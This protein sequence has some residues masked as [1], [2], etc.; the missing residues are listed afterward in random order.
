MEYGQNCRR[1]SHARPLPSIDPG[2]ISNPDEEKKLRDPAHQDRLAGA[3]HAGVRRYFYDNPPPGS[4]VAGLAAA[5]R[6]QALRQTAAQGE[7]PVAGT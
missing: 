5:E 2:A 7:I 6:S 1:R 3:I 4:R